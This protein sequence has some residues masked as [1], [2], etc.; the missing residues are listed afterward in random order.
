[1]RLP[2]LVEVGPVVLERKI[3]KFRQCILTILLLSP[4]GKGWGPTFEQNLNPLYPRML[5]AKF[6]RNWPC[7]FGEEDKNVKS[8]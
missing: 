5:C 1:M 4:L 3:F 2:S 6:N 8:L 7:G